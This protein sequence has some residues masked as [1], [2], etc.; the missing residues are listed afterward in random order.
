MEW[1]TLVAI[2]AGVP[3]SF[4]FH[5]I[6]IQLTAPGFGEAMQTMA[7]GVYLGDAWWI[8]G[9][10]RSLTALAVVEAD[11]ANK[12]LPSLP[13]TVAAVL[14]ACGKVKKTVQVPLPAAP[15]AQQAGPDPEALRRVGQIVSDYKSRFPAIVERLPFPHDLPPL[16]EALQAANLGV[17]AGPKKPA[18]VRAFKP[19]GYDCVGGSGTFTLRR[20]T[21]GHLTVEIFLDVGTWSHSF[22]GSF[23]VQG[24]GFKARLNL[25][26]SRRGGATQYP[27]GDE[28][29]WRKIVDNI[30]AVVAELDSTFVPAIEAAAGPTPEWYRPEQ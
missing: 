8:N 15:E 23:S 6:V 19:M 20:R 17:T 2:A 7:P 4:P 30:A 10:S 29:R 22:T 21:G 25:P 18:L 16:L 27:I 26:V 1:R 9:R 5:N 24:L 13:A 3:R 11:P 12:K 28:E 14:A